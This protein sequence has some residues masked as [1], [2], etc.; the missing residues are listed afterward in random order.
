MLYG[1]VPL[2]CCQVVQINVRSRP[3]HCNC[4]LQW[5]DLETYMHAHTWTHRKKI[6]LPTNC[7]SWI[8]AW[9]VLIVL[10]VVYRE[11]YAT[12]LSNQSNQVPVY[13]KLMLGCSSYVQWYYNIHGNPYFCVLNFLICKENTQYPV[14][15]SNY[16]YQYVCVNV[17]I[18]LFLLSRDMWIGLSLNSSYF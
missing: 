4:Q 14:I 6:A 7:I 17:R 9:E 2:D 16:C 5:L 13:T 10:P 11:Y 3:T 1:G 8:V 18:L 12:F 15:A